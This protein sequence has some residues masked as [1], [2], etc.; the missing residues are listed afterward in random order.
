MVSDLVKPGQFNILVYNFL[1]LDTDSFRKKKCRKKK[2][3]IYLQEIQ[4]NHGCN[5]FHK[6]A[7][8][9]I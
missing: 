4:N 3:L 9:F 1:K 6:L 7:L 2:I 8:Y 5:I